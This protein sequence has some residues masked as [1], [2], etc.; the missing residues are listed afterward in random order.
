MRDELLLEDESFYFEGFET[1]AD[2]TEGMSLEAETGGE[3]ARW[4]QRALN[5]VMGLRLAVDG[6]I[7]A[8]TRS[9]IRSFQQ[10]SGLVADG[11]V[12]KKTEAALLAAGAP[13]PTGVTPAPL[14][15]SGGG[16]TSGACVGIKGKEILDSFRQ[17]SADP[18]SDH[19]SRIN[20]IALCIRDMQSAPNPI[21][22]VDIV[23]HT[24]VEGAATYNE[25]LGQRRADS[26]RLRLFNALKRILPGLESRVE[27]RASSRGEREPRGGTAEADRRVEIHLPFVVPPIPPPPPPPLPK[28]HT[29][30][31]ALKSYIACIGSRVGAPACTGL[32]V[33]P[34]PFPPIPSTA[35]MRIQLLAA[36]V[37]TAFCEDPRT[38][39]VIKDY[40]LF[41][42]ASF[43]VVSAGGTLLSATG[44]LVT[45]SG[46]ECEP[47]TKKLC[48]QA[49]PLFVVKPLTITKTGPTTFDFT[50]TV[51]GRPP[52]PA[53][54]AMNNICPRTSVFI[55]HTISGRVDVSSGRPV[56]SIPVFG[57]S[58]FPTHRV[59][60]DG[61]IRS[62]V[63]QRDFINLWI[64]SPTDATLV[65]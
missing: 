25:Q 21:R 30:K 61:A 60:V 20:Q 37:D 38:D 4:I 28:V 58:N 45:D 50:W 52:G 27:L 55:W 26:V 41:S 32:T 31:V 12:G 53:E 64:A 46:K 18:K 24:S 7:G 2:E 65:Q 22:R 51:K 63:P 5:S 23:G 49:P 3:Y 19:D 1:E 9:A 59:F 54:I 56:V 16:G 8:Q 29:V 11:I 44:S 39:A 40:R 43:N 6:V 15:P 62:T 33:A 47:I 34:P 35:A 48:L 17:D 14:L 57:G 42:G 13:A 36:A 10:R